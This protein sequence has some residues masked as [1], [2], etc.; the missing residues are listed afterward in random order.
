M[1]R[2]GPFLA[3]LGALVALIPAAASAAAPGGG[4]AIH[5]VFIIVLENE[6]A[7]TTFGPG[8]PAPY[9]AGPLRAQGAFVPNYYGTGHNS[10]D[11]YIAMISGQAPNPQSQADCQMFTDLLPGTVGSG[12]Q[13]QGTGC[14]Y[15]AGVPTIASQLDQAG[16]TWRS[17]N[18]SMGAD[19]SREAS[20]CAHPAIGASDN[21]QTATASDEY[22]TR[23]NPFVYFHQII[24]NTTECNSRVVGLD[25]LSGDLASV[26]TTPNYTFITPDLC[27]DGHDAPCKNGQPGGL[28][29][30][31]AF[32]QTWV[33]KITASPA[34]RQDGLLMILFDEASASDTSSCCG[35]IP[36]PSS[37]SPGIGGPGGGRTGAVLLSPCIA[38][39][40]VTMTPYNHYSMLAS[41]EDLFGLSHLGYAAGP[42]ATAFT[43]DIYNRPCGPAPPT[44]SVRPVPPLLSAVTSS[45]RVTVRWSASTAG[46]TPLSGYTVRYE[47]LRGVSGPAR[48][49]LTG[50]AR[51]SLTF[52]GR[53]GHSY[54]FAVSAGNQAG[55]SSPFVSTG[56]VVVPSGVRP[57]GGHY[58]RGWR[59]RRVRGAWLG[60]AIVTSRRG[61]GF[62]LRYRG[63][64][65]TLIGERG[66]GGGVLRVSVDGRAH[67]VR[68]HAARRAVRR[69]VLH[70]RLGPGTHRVA[71]RVL[72]GTVALEGYGTLAR[73]R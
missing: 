69:T 12:G 54:A 42:G 14:V 17:Y 38:P 67:T 66:P 4:S 48:V 60:H 56:T 50:T 58:S 53:A 8:S 15:P 16:F 19:P 10:N 61:A 43:S 29:S 34:Y 7:A 64:D 59:V 25:P 26:A 27:H 39:G 13:A 6:S 9:L 70:V 20:V 40:T 41:V 30:A 5:H 37:P 63:R 1:R 45:P 28:V 62:A 46:G 3:L 71:V 73:S 51:T 68:L 35:E 11:N 57:S 65:L 55:Q 47:D 23:H 18:E 49:L 44:A 52:R 33:P 32:L 72:R 31:N 24:D 22:A 2:L 21:T 36:G